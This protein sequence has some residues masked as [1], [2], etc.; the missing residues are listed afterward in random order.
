MTLDARIAV[1]LPVVPAFV[2]LVTEEM[3]VSILDSAWEILL[4]LQVLEAIGLIPALGEDIEGDLAADGVSVPPIFVSAN[5]AGKFCSDI[6]EIGKS[7]F[8]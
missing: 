6:C 1:D 8:Q 5:S 7:A 4:I 3:N 2:R